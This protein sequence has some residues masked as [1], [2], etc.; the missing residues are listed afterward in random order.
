MAGDALRA[1]PVYTVFGG[2]ENSRRQELAL[3]A[4]AACVI[5]RLRPPGGAAPIVG[6]VFATFMLMG[7]Q[8]LPRA[9]QRSTAVV[10][11]SL[12]GMIIVAMVTDKAIRPMDTLAVIIGVIAGRQNEGPNWND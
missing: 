4:I 10:D 8:S 9:Q 5:R 6:V 2:G 12:G 1:S 7:I 3:Q 11:G